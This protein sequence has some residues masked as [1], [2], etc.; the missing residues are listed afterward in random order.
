MYILVGDVIANVIISTTLK[1]TCMK[2]LAV[3]DKL[4]EIQ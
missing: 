4:Q 1:F 2:T 3:T